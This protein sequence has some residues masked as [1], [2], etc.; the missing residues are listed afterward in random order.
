MLSAPGDP[1]QQ[2]QGEEH[3][4]GGHIRAAGAHSADR[5][6]DDDGGW[7]PSEADGGLAPAARTQQVRRRTPRRGRSVPSVHVQ[8]IGE[9]GGLARPALDQ[10]FQPALVRRGMLAGRGATRFSPSHT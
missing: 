3:A 5:T 2:F 10:H 8:L 1:R 7:P 6:G 4:A 9:A